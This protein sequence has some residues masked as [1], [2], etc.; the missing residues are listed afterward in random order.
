MPRREDEYWA[1]QKENLRYCS[2]HKRYYRVDLGCQICWQE[3]QARR[4]HCEEPP[5]LRHCPKCRLVS[6]FGNP[7]LN[8]YECLNRRCDKQFTE[9]ELE[10]TEDNAP[11]L[12]NCP[13]CGQK[14]VT[15]VESFNIFQ[16]VNSKCKRVFTAS[17]WNIIR[18]ASAYLPE[19]QEDKNKPNP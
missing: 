11:T 1:S 5:Q 15:L 3:R 13:H 2:A 6:L 19:K 9:N 7:S 18:Q 10:T 17:E 4:L 12:Q 14:T 8:L 16:C